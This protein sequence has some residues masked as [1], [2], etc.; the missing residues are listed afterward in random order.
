MPS[1]ID[2]TIKTLDG[3]SRKFENIS[4]EI[5][6]KE[7]KE[8]IASRV[9]IPADK[10]R[11]IYAGRVLNDSNVLSSY[12]LDGQAIHL[13]ERQPVSNQPN[14][15][16]SS[17]S[18]PNVNNPNVRP[19]LGRSG[20]P[21]PNMPRTQIRMVFGGNQAPGFIRP[22]APGAP[23]FPPPRGPPRFMPQNGGTVRFRVPRPPIVSNA[24]RPAATPVDAGSNR[25]EHCRKYIASTK[26]VLRHLKRLKDRMSN[27][28]ESTS[29]SSTTTQEDLEIPAE[30]EVATAQTNEQLD[31]GTASSGAPSNQTEETNSQ[32][33]GTENAQQQSPNGANGETGNGRRNR[34]LPRAY[35]AAEIIS[36][37][38]NV[39][40]CERE[41]QE[42]VDLCEN[43]FSSSDVEQAQNVQHMHNV[44]IHGIGEATHF[45]AHAQH[46]LSDLY[47]NL[48]HRPPV[49]LAHPVPVNAVAATAIEIAP[50]LVNANGAAIP[51]PPM[52]MG[53]PPGP[54][55]AG[56]PGNADQQ[57]ANMAPNSNNSGSN[58]NSTSTPNNTP[59]PNQA[60][61]NPRMP[62]MPP[63]IPTFAAPIF[64]MPPGAIPTVIPGP[65]PNMVPGAFPNLAPGAFPNMGPGQIPVNVQRFT[66]PGSNDTIFRASFR[67]GVPRGNHAASQ[68]TNGN[69][70]TTT[71]Q[72]GTPNVVPNPTE[73]TDASSSTDARPEA[74]QNNQSDASQQATMPGQPRFPIRPEVFG[75][76]DPFVPCNSRFFQPRPPRGATGGANASAASQQ[77]NGSNNTTSAGESQNA[78]ENV[79]AEQ[80][81]TDQSA[82]V[83][84][85]VNM[86]GLGLDLQNILQSMAAANPGINLEMNEDTVA[87]D[88]NRPIGEQ[89]QDIINSVMSATAAGGTGFGGNSE[90]NYGD[91][92][93]DVQVNLEAQ[94]G[95]P[96]EDGS[97]SDEH[98]FYGS[99]DIPDQQPVPPNPLH[100]MMAGFLQSGMGN[101][102]TNLFDLLQMGQ[103][104][105]SGILNDIAV[106]F[107]RSISVPELFAILSGQT[108]ALAQVRT[109]LREFVQQSVLRGEGYSEDLLQRRISESIR[110]DHS[111]ELLNVQFNET[112]NGQE[113]LFR[114]L[115]QRVFELLQLTMND[116]VG[117]NE[118]AQNVTTFFSNFMFEMIVLYTNILHSSQRVESVLANTLMSDFLRTQS[119]SADNESSDSRQPPTFMGMNISG[120]EPM[121][122][123]L[124]SQQLSNLASMASSRVPLSQVEQFI[125]RRDQP[126]IQQPNSA[127][128]N[129]EPKSEPMDCSEGS[130]IG[131]ANSGT[132]QSTN[133][134]D[135]AS[136]R[137]QQ[138]PVRP[139]IKQPLRAQNSHARLS[140]N[141]LLPDEPES[142][143]SIFDTNTVNEATENWL[144]VLKNDE[145]KQNEESFPDYFS[146]AYLFGMP[147]RQRAM[148]TSTNAFGYEGSMRGILEGTLQRMSSGSS[149]NEATRVALRDSIEDDENL[150]ELFANV[151]RQDISR[152]YDNDPDMQNRPSTKK[153]LGK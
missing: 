2:I 8:K 105:A 7:L 11:L 52:N 115:E 100:S 144:E 152:R 102:Q 136:Q 129:V 98:D 59:N 108:P 128:Q 53:V 63:F 147:P 123:M 124:V 86:G 65:F 126:M 139:K 19:P 14:A 109:P 117:D 9:N 93:T 112:V 21:N 83:G 57:A 70:S 43:I 25:V 31:D 60:N 145:Q 81:T 33:E 132:N 96:M 79:S 95:D 76:R 82:S 58:Q 99:G 49:A 87:V 35:P 92:Q 131:V 111:F 18:G 107:A 66:V 71:A 68:P 15:S 29:E 89:I 61:F 110:G 40:D 6:V 5:T 62:Q 45:L 88:P 150:Q 113:S 17:A 133:L 85:Q 48:S 142:M 77:P 138:Q 127:S 149:A 54:P 38:R 114:F 94:F 27:L 3:N 69:Q 141:V 16:S 36:L 39:N 80:Q 67:A 146:D 121:I 12:N 34:R 106:V 119:R 55:P 32:A 151:V 91:V 134:S 135:G 103:E 24:G 26:H 137:K 143:N 148:A 13:V 46:S 23:P 4:N 50:V 116:E 97:Y 78:N 41:L 72:R 73:Q 22:G 44:L 74:A 64:N 28:E 30:P 47:T 122:T 140:F 37:H 104:Q 153:Y 90:E 20:R 1:T 56:G 125:V 10:Q 101:P 118:F 42:Y 75:P 120:M 84:N 51:I 130:S